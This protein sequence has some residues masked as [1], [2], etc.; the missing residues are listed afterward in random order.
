MQ[1]KLE[2]LARFA[3]NRWK[4]GLPEP[5]HAHPDEEMISCFLEGRLDQS[6]VLG[7]KEHLISCRD[8]AEALAMNIKIKGLKEEDLPPGLVNA[9]KNMLL[10]Q[11]SALILEIALRIKDKF[12]EIINTTGDVLVGQE[13]LP[14]P[15]VRSR[16]IKGFKDEVVILKDFKDIRVEVKVESKGANVFNL[17][18]LIKDKQTQKPIKDLRIT[19]I[20]DDLELESYLSA[21]GSVSFEHVALGKYRLDISSPKEN[22]AS[23]LVDINI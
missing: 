12:F 2:G 5:G 13:F 18:I 8:C 9:V 20:K 7:I 4:L 16:S 11:G 22:L 6:E 14:A 17:A 23:V 10:R 19:L 3:Y 1:D 15:V 21:L